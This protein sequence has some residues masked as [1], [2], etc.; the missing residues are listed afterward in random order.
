MYGPSPSAKRTSK[1]MKQFVIGAVVAIV[2]II[3]I[4]AIILGES[5]GGLQKE[6]TMREFDETFLEEDEFD[7]RYDGER[8][9][10]VDTIGQIEYR[11]N[12]HCPLMTGMII[13]T[14]DGTGINLESSENSTPD[15]ES[16]FDIAFWDQDLTDE[17]HPGEEVRITVLIEAESVY[18]E[19]IWVHLDF[20]IEEI[21]HA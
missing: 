14:H 16:E 13:G 19:G 17:H 9:Y 20:T 11:D 7:E 8:V 10:I 21:E 3:V 5:G 18:G 12:V 4:L 2:F 6:F 1:R 15:G